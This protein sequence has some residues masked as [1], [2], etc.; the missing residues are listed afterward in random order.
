[1]ILSVLSAPNYERIVLEVIKIKHRSGRKFS[2]KPQILMEM[3]LMVANRSSY[4]IPCALS[5]SRALTP[6]RFS[7][8][9]LPYNDH[10]GKTF[11]MQAAVLSLIHFFF[12]AD[13]FVRP[14]CNRQRVHP[15]FP[16]QT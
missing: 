8:N 12:V 13:P 11:A 6:S 2:A 5:P 3:D 7:N 14:D 15:S 10:H 4:L 9:C 16:Q 1:M